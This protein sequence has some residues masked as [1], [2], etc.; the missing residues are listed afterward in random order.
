MVARSSR[1]PPRAS[2]ASLLNCERRNTRWE[3]LLYPPPMPT[4]RELHACRS[5]CRPDPGRTRRA[6]RLAL[7]A[8]QPAGARLRSRMRALL[9][10][11]W[12]IT[13]F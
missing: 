7:D 6:K 4:S 5:G 3:N 2:S 10:T 9:A 11:T 13:F 8:Q 12:C 1:V